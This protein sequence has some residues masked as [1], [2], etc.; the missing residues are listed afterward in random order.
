MSLS[1]ADSAYSWVWW[2]ET[3]VE[4]CVWNSILGVMKDQNEA[5]YN[6]AP[7]LELMYGAEPLVTA[8]LWQR[9]IWGQKKKK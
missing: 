7:T 4:L 9:P 3:A 8:N 6:S 5:S 2:G 1:I